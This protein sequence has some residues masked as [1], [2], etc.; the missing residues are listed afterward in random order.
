MEEIIDRWTDNVSVLTWAVCVSAVWRRRPASCELCAP[1]SESER[2]PAPWGGPGCRRRRG[3]PPGGG[4]SRGRTTASRRRAADPTAASSWEKP[5]RSLCCPA[6]PPWT[7]RGRGPDSAPW[8][9]IWRLSCRGWTSPRRRR[10][11]ERQ[12]GEVLGERWTSA[13]CWRETSAFRAWPPSSTKTVS[14]TPWWGSRRPPSPRYTA[15]ANMLTRRGGAEICRR[16][17]LNFL[18]GLSRFWHVSSISRTSSDLNRHLT[19]HQTGGFIT[20]TLPAD[21]GRLG[22]FEMARPLAAV[23]LAVSSTTTITFLR[24]NPIS[25]DTRVKNNLN[26]VLQPLGGKT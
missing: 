13:A 16:E 24:G 17:K 22:K 8:P 7:L 18:S 19:P 11:E 25:F 20:N 5:A 14:T 21:H 10:S 26:R 9:A 2:P 6:G 1:S 23:W 12:R 3:A 4:G 15:K